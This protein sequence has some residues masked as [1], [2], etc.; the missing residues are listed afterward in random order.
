[1]LGYLMRYILKSQPHLICSL[2]LDFQLNLTAS[3]LQ[4]A[5]SMIH[6]RIK[7]VTAT[8]LFQVITGHL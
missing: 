4:K 8:I 1:M 3:K 6:D 2:F 7:N 5:D